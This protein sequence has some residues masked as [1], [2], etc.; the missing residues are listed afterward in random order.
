MTIASFSQRQLPHC[1]RLADT[2][3]VS[4]AS[5]VLI[6]Y[7]PWEVQIEN[8]ITMNQRHNEQH[9]DGF[10][11]DCARIHREWHERARTVDTDGL[12]ALY[13]EDAVFESPLVSAIL[14]GKRDRVLSGQSKLRHFFTE[15]ARRRPNDLVRWYRTGAWLTDERRFLIRE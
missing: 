3:V 5:Q 2:S 4:E 1:E 13:A 11:S 6:D 10:L 7:V 9:P 12:L 8:D 14:D 15:G